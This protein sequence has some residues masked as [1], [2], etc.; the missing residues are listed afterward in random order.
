MKNGTEHATRTAK[1][2]L[3][4]KL[5]ERYRWFYSVRSQYIVYAE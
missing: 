2:K 4:L 3:K 1:Y 5:H